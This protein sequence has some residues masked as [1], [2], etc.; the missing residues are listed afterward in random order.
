MRV[1]L[2]IIQFFKYSIVGGIAFLADVGTI[3]LFQEIILK[4][5]FTK[6]YISTAIG[7]FVGLIVNFCLSVRYV[8]QNRQWSGYKEKLQKL[9]ETGIAGIVGLLITEIGMYIA[10][11]WLKVQYVLGKIVVAGVV[12]LWNYLA[13]LLWIFKS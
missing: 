13:R 9:M 6:L 10:V 4:N 12:F 5:V 7:F 1:K 8:F 2:N 3:C 11:R